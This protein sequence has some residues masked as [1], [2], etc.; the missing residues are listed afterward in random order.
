MYGKKTEGYR[1]G[2]FIAW[3]GISPERA[4]ELAR[5]SAR[6]EARVH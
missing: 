3:G 2:P 1:N 5:T 4:A 6:A